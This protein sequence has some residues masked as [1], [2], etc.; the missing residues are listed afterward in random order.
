MEVD[1]GA[2][3][4]LLSEFL[5]RQ[6]GSPSLNQSNKLF[7]AY[8]GHRMKPVGEL[9]S[10]VEW[11]GHVVS[12]ATITVVHSSKPYGLLG[13][14]LI[15][16]LCPQTLSI[17]STQEHALPVMKVKPVRIE[18]E[19]RSTLKFCRA[20]PVPLPMKQA[21]EDVLTSLEKRSIIRKVESSQ[22]ASPVVWI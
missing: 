21:V 19:D 11:D 10:T 9:V 8:D 3:A 13:R 1:T 14:D 22:F 7:T 12:D 4:T 18:I 6:I 16:K 2:S 5:W 20:R 17:H 15:E